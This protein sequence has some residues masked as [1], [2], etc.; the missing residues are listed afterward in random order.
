MQENGKEF[1]KIT[2]DNLHL[3]KPGVRVCFPSSNKPFGTFI[4]KEVIKW[5]RELEN[6]HGFSD[7]W[8]ITYNY[9][10]NPQKK[11]TIIIC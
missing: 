9:E 8:Y 2:K 6:T 11:Q 7:S 5:D 3:I 1:I 4:S 10:F